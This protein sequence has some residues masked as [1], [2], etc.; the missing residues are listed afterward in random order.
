MATNYLSRVDA[1]IAS[2]ID[3]LGAE[4]RARRFEYIASRQMPDGGFAGRVPGSDVYYTDFGVRAAALLDPRC[5]VLTG[6]HQYLRTLDPRPRCVVECFNRL[7][8]VRILG[9]FQRDCDIDTDAVAAAVP[10]QPDGVYEVFL[11][12]LCHELLGRT[13]PPTADLVRPMQRAN[14][15]FSD[16]D[17]DAETAQTNATAAAIA[18]LDMQ[19]ALDDETAEAAAGFL[20][21]AQTGDGGFR[22]HP[23][24]PEPDLLSTFTAVLSLSWLDRLRRADTAAVGRFLQSL[25]TKKGGFRA[26]KSDKELDV[27][28]AY[29]GVATAALLR[30]HADRTD[31]GRQ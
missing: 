3:G 19:D 15:G 1:L 12:A 22:A 10:A 16:L 8:I 17:D 4:F 13:A 24:A 5:E 23:T 2:G 27:E 14:G 18:V 25:S 11:V 20:I 30:R 29:Y 7:N 6:V 21:A 9:R 31:A 28:Y 26:S